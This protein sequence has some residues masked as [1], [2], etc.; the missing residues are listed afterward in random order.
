MAVGEEHL[1]SVRQDILALIASQLTPV[2]LRHNY[3]QGPLEDAVKW[4]PMVLIVGSYSSGKS[5]FVNELIGAPVQTVG[6]APTDD[7]FTVLTY[8]EEGDGAVRVVEE[9]AGASVLSDP[10]Y[11]FSGLRG[12]GEGLAGHFRVKRVASPLLRRLALVDTP[13]MLETAQGLRRDYDFDAA[14]GQLAAMADL[15]LVLFDALKAGAAAETLATLRHALLPQVPASRLVFVMNRVDRVTTLADLLR[16]SGALHWNLAATLMTKDVP[17]VVYAWA[18]TAEATPAHLAL[19]ENGR[20]EMARVV[21]A[22]PR[23]RL[24]HLLDYVE[25]HG[26]RLR[27]LAGALAAYRGALV[28]ARLAV[29]ARSAGVALLLALAAFGIMYFSSEERPLGLA[30]VTAASAFGLALLCGYALFGP[31]LARATAT[32]LA[33]GEGLVPLDDALQKSTWAEVQPTFARQ[34]A[35]SPSGKGLALARKDHHQLGR[36]LGRDLAELR[37]SL[38]RD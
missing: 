10:A 25:R 2:A 12:L 14:L 4:Q 21:A 33:H 7:S 34:V 22:A 17:R 32:R 26:G 30:G 37:K 35:A 6:E 1:E 3:A 5:T 11:P 24:D 18:A 20:D 31:R 9:R 23:L 15:V 8:A 13:G 29:L 19:L 36:T 28:K 16:V 38:P 27:M